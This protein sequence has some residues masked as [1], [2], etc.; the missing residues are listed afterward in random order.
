[1]KATR[2]NLKPVLQPFKRADDDTDDV[3]NENYVD[4]LI[5]QGSREAKTEVQTQ[6]ESSNATRKMEDDKD[7]NDHKNPHS[8]CSSEEEKMDRREEEQIR[9]KSEEYLMVNFPADVRKNLKGI[10]LP[11]NEQ[12]KQDMCDVNGRVVSDDSVPKADKI[13]GNDSTRRVVHV[14]SQIS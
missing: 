11:K 9:R 8:F 3:N 10:M 7:S 2:R 14:P 5:R 12:T 6:P 4:R 13:E 1:M